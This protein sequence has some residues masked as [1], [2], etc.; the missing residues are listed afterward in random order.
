[1]FWMTDLS[2]VELVDRARSGD[3]EAMGHLFERHYTMVFRLAWRWCGVRDD[4]ED[5]AQETFVKL[6]R[7]L[8]TFRRRASFKTWL[9]RIAVNTARDYGRRH[10]ARRSREEEY[11]EHQGGHNPGSGSVDGT[12]AFRLREALDSLPAAQR[13]AV[14]LVFS[15]GMSHR[16]ASQVLGCG[17]VTVSWRIFRARARL[18]TFLEQGT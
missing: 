9:Y 11:D 18:K 16:E 17:E 7:K 3:A 5:I 4:A 10:G 2:D 1:M 8:K 12:A 6:V 15:E 13:E 14:L